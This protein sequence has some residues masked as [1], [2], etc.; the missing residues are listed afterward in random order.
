[1]ANKILW[2]A[3]PTSRGNVLSTQLNALADNAYT[4]QGAEV[5]NSTNLDTYGMFEFNVDATA[6]FAAGGYMAIYLITAPD[7]TNYGEGSASVVPGADTWLLNIPLRATA[8][9]IIKMTK[10]FPL[11]PVKFKFIMENQGGR[12]FPTSGSTL[13]LFTMNYELQ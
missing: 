13:E 2:A 7:G 9:A 4:A 3:A 11:P 8:D 12:V 6:A 10:V 5:D 1:M